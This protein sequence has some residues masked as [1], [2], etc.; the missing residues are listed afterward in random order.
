MRL[1]PPLNDTL[2]GENVSNAMDENIL[3]RVR[4]SSCDQQVKN[5]SDSL[6]V[7]DKNLSDSLQPTNS[8]ETGAPTNTYTNTDTNTV[9]ETYRCYVQSPQPDTGVHIQNQT[10]SPQPVFD[11]IFAPREDV[12][13]DGNSYVWEMS[14]LRETRAKNPL[15]STGKKKYITLLRLV[16]TI[17]WLHHIVTSNAHV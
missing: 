14:P 10:Q 3:D 17:K 1:N 11:E 16:I 12:L 8:S 6:L 2:T 4:Y 13:G 7:L 15:T 9:N 5:I